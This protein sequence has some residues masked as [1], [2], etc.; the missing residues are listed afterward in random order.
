MLSRK[1]VRLCRGEGA[2]CGIAGVVDLTGRRAAP[3]EVLQAM[4][5]A[6]Y[7]RGPDEEGFLQ[8]D[9]VSLASRRLS[10]VGLF[11]GQQPIA[12]EDGSISVV[13]N[14]ELFDYPERRADLEAR[15]H[16][17]RTHC[18]TELL[19]HLWEDHG[20]AMLQKLRGQYAIA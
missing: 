6:L 13:F 19:P 9:K 5:D 7:H 15:G 2:M 8:Q 14:G 18:D 17:F 10:I 11:D 16:R 1:H 12:N 3:P 20:E 4:A